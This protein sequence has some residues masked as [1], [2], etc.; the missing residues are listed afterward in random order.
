[1]PDGGTNRPAA[2]GLDLVDIRFC[3]S[4]LRLHRLGP[5]AVAEL[6]AE[7]GAR[8]LIRQPIEGLVDEYLARLDPIRLV[9]LRGRGR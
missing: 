8:H 2:G 1:V 5:R 6:L 9:V 3:R 4:V 7:L